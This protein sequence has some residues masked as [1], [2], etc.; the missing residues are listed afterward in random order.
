ML[1]RTEVDQGW[2]KRAQKEEKERSN[3]LYSRLVGHSTVASLRNL[4]VISKILAFIGGLIVSYKFVEGTVVFILIDYLLDSWGQKKKHIALVV[5]NLHDGLSRLLF[6]IV[7]QISE[8][9]T[10]CFNMITYCA[11][12]SILGLVLLWTSTSAFGAVYAALVL[13]ALGK[14]GQMLSENF[15]EDQLQDHMDA[16]H[17][18]ISLFVP[19]FVVYIMTIYYAFHEYLTY[20]SRF[21]FAAFLMLGAYVLFLAGSML[22]SEEELSDESNLGKIYRIIKAAIGKCKLKYPASPIFYYWKDYKQGHWYSLGE[23]VRLKPHVPRLFRWLDKAAIVTDS[24]DSNEVNPEIQEKNGKLCTVKEV[25]EVKSLVPMI[26]LGFTFFGYSFLLASGNTFFVS[27]ASTSESVI[28]NISGNDIYILNLIKEVTNDMS[29][30]IYFLIL[31]SLVRLKVID[32]MP[33]R[34]QATIIRV[35]FGMFCA[36]I[37]CLIAWQVEIARLSKDTNTTVALVPQFILLG[38]AEGLVDGGFENLFHGHVVRS[39]WGFEDSFSELVIGFGKLFVTPF[40]LILSSW[41]DGSYNTS[42]LD[43]C[44]LMLGVVNGMFL[45]IFGYYS[46]KYAYKETCPNDENVT[47]EESLEPIY[48]ENNNEAQL[49]DQDNKLIMAIFN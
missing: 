38:M 16:V 23:G 7:S 39:M 22:Y 5:T 37:C 18:K 12:L 32:F 25:R 11:P 10:G 40:V 9:Y 42:H 27:Q 49:V 3:E 8:K 46:Y 4:S 43:R 21:R 30:F 13:L 33:K 19:S 28:T 31:Q 26:Y 20:S 44:F 35:G 48:Q 2:V 47:L 15:L 17:I 14:G 36:V 1:D 29:R 34:K 45:L 41:F 6:V 24:N